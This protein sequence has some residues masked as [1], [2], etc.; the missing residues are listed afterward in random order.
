MIHHFTNGEEVFQTK[1]DIIEGESDKPIYVDYDTQNFQRILN[2]YRSAVTL[3]NIL[4]YDLERLEKAIGCDTKTVN[5]QGKYFK[6]GTETLNSIPYIKSQLSFVSSSKSTIDELIDRDPNIFKRVISWVR[7][8]YTVIDDETIEEMRFYGFSKFDIPCTLKNYRFKEI[9]ERPNKSNEILTAIM[10]DGSDTHC[11]SY[12]KDFLQENN[13][14]P[15]LINGPAFND[16]CRNS[17]HITHSKDHSF[18]E[19]YFYVLTRTPN[20]V[21]IVEMIQLNIQDCTV[22][23]HSGHS[24]QCLQDFGFFEKS[25]YVYDRTTGIYHMLIKFDFTTLSSSLSFILKS[26]DFSVEI[27]W[28]ND[29]YKKTENI[30]GGKCFAKIEKTDSIIDQNLFAISIETIQDFIYRNDQQ[31]YIKCEHPKL[32]FLKFYDSNDEIIDIDK[33]TTIDLIIDSSKTLFERYNSDANKKSQLENFGIYNPKY[34]L[35]DI[36]NPLLSNEIYYS[37]I[38]RGKKKFNISVFALSENQII[39]TN[40]HYSL[41]V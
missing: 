23:K 11:V 25:A 33:N 18:S 1:V 9:V 10:C 24:I 7:N 5:V 29:Y 12:N 6:V 28:Y 30:I 35:I 3:D 41:V 19:I 39:Y 34:W 21:D 20:I 38:I 36:I 15:Q 17:I 14:Y 32:V 16:G 31:I 4:K 37:L 22:L 26:Q 13:Y 2:Y 27:E 40:M 8:P